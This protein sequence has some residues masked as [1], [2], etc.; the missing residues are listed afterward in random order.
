MFLLIL[1]D[2]YPT[3]LC[4]KGSGFPVLQMDVVEYLN[5]RIYFFN[6]DLLPDFIQ[7]I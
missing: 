7:K 4:F 6:I 5:Q 1:L 3:K 2:Q